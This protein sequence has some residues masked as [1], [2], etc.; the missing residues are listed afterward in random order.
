MNIPELQ[1]TSE[2]NN[3]AGITLVNA[4]NSVI[5]L[6]NQQIGKICSKAVTIPISASHTE[7]GASFTPAITS[8]PNFYNA[9]KVN[10]DNS[11]EDY[12]F[13]ISAFVPNADG[14]TWD[15]VFG[16][17]DVEITGLIVNVQ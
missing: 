2:T 4:I 6:I 16:E 9:I 13:V 5:R 12:S 15:V 11:I 14:V 10:G 7:L 8:R 1:I 3:P 17:T